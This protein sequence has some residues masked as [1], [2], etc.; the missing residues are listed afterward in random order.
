MKYCGCAVA[1]C[2][3]PVHAGTFATNIFQK[4]IYRSVVSSTSC[5]QLSGNRLLRCGCLQLKTCT[6]RF[7][8]KP[9]YENVPAGFLRGNL[10]D[11]CLLWLMA[12]S[13]ESLSAVAFVYQP[14]QTQRLYIARR[15]EQTA[16]SVTAALLTGVLNGRLKGWFCWPAA[17]VRRSICHLAP[18][19]L[20][21]HGL[22]SVDNL[23]PYVCFHQLT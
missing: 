2:S 23:V 13:Q 3:R 18:C 8:P 11:F 1:F 9:Q 14:K 6:L 19:Q 15:N 20:S 16:G 7:K 12:G 17:L 10:L 4:C 21:Q 22:P 5:L